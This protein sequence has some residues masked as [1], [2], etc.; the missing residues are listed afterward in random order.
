MDWSFRSVMHV[1]AW[2]GAFQVS[3]AGRSIV[4]SFKSVLLGEAW[5]GV[6]GQYSRKQHRLEFQIMEYFREKHGLFF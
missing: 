2:I 5:I 6:S 1:E 4:C 3:T